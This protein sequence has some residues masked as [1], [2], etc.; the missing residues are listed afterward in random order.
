MFGLTL[1][2]VFVIAVVGVLILAGTQYIPP[3][4]VHYQLDNTVKN[5]V[6]FAA[7]ARRS[8]DAVRRDV[9][10]AAREAGIELTPEDIS[11]ERDGTQF[12]LS[13]AYTWPVNMRAYQQSLTFEISAT[14]EA[15]GQ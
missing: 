7:P 2:R 15:F 13:F 4:V 9:V 12:T 11:I 1:K 6:R 14:G 5:A 3:Y 8:M 10:A